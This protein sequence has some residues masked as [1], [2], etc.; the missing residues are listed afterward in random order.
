[1]TAVRP[2]GPLPT[3]PLSPLITTLIA[4]FFEV[5]PKQTDLT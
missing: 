4:V 5:T 3:G 2:N 1:M